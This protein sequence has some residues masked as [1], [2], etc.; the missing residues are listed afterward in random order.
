DSR[1]DRLL[2]FHGSEQDS[3]GEVTAYDFRS[4]AASLLSPAG[5]EKAGLP[6]RETTYLTDADM[7]LIQAHVEGSRWLIY[8]CAANAW[9]GVKL[10]GPE[11]IGNQVFN[12]SLG[13]TYDSNRRL[14]W[15]LGQHSE[16]WVL[17]FDRQTADVQPL[18]WMDE[19]IAIRCAWASH[20]L[21]GTPVA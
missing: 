7:V 6:S 5:K 9:F 8:D 10:A 17:R 16:V 3:S 1:R 19:P 2:C 4:G 12:N 20:A 21:P 14:I 18:R 13:L 15:A 11:L